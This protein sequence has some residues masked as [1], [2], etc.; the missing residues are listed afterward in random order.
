M[1]KW[2][3]VIALLPSLMQL[4]TMRDLL[5]RDVFVAVDRILFDYSISSICYQFDVLNFNTVYSSMHCCT[6]QICMILK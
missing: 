3:E 4:V 6:L 5:T 2:T 1:D